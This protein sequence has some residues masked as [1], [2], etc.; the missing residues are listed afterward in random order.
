MKK[1]IAAAMLMLATTAHADVDTLCA[2]VATNAELVAKHRQTIR[3]NTVQDVVDE[4]VR[5]SSLRQY[6][7]AINREIYLNRLLPSEAH[8]LVMAT[9]KGVFK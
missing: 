8:A 3:L 4:T 2:S 6:V 1:L 9:C 5:D 7:F